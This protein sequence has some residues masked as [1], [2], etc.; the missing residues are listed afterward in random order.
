MMSC[1]VNAN[2]QLG[3]LLNKIKQKVKEKVEIILLV[4]GAWIVVVRRHI[5]DHFVRV[6]VPNVE[7]L[8]R[9]RIL[10]GSENADHR[11]LTTR[12]RQR[13]RSRCS[14]G[15]R[16]RQDRVCRFRTSSCGTTIDGTGIRIDMNSVGESRTCA[17]VGH[18]ENVRLNVH[19]TVFGVERVGSL[20]IRYGLRQHIADEELHFV[21]RHRRSGSTLNGHADSWRRHRIGGTHELLPRIGRV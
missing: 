7:T 11:A 20:G 18:A 6:R 12:K 4:L 2:A 10:V 13:D 14:D 9:S 8:S 21:K 16:L 19:G 1:S 15:A 3:G 5:E 17:A